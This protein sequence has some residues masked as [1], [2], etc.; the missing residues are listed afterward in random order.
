LGKR[1]PARIAPLD[2]GQSCLPPFTSSLRGK[3]FTM[4]K[5]KGGE[6]MTRL[7]RRNKGCVNERKKGGTMAF[8]EE[9]A[10]VRNPEKKKREAIRF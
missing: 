9:A 1:N 10:A 2:E 8:L 5:G 7:V 6:K 3:G 4:Q